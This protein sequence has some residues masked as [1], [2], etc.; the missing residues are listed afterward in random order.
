MSES[1]AISK[2]I[3]KTIMEL[4]QNLVELPMRTDGEYEDERVRDVRIIITVA[5]RALRMLER[6]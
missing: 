6:K 1:P 2:L 3:Q 4:E 5:A